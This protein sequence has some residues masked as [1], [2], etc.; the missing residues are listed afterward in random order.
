[1]AAAVIHVAPTRRCVDDVLPADAAHRLAA[2]KSGAAG[3]KGAQHTGAGVVDL[4]GVRENPRAAASARL[5]AVHV[6]DG[7]TDHVAPQRFPR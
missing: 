7:G 1:M 3:A 4:V 5:T 6:V 2:C